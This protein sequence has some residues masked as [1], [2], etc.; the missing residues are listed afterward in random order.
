M[1]KEKQIWDLVS[2]LLEEY[3]YELNGISIHQ[4]DDF[5]DKFRKIYHHEGYCFELKRFHYELTEDE[6]CKDCIE[7]DGNLFEYVFIEPWDGFKEA[8]IDKA[9]ELLKSYYD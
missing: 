9:I 3:G 2:Y 8:G 5:E 7:E 6:I 1:N 4:H